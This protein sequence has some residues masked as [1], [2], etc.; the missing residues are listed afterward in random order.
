MIKCHKTGGFF[1]EKYCGV[2]D[3]PTMAQMTFTQCTSI[4]RDL[5][6]KP[7]WF[8][9][10]VAAALYTLPCGDASHKSD[11]PCSNSY[12]SAFSAKA[13]F[14]QHKLPTHKQGS[15]QETWA[16]HG[17][18]VL[19]YAACYLYRTQNSGSLSRCTFDTALQHRLYKTE[20]S[21]AILI[22]ILILC[23]IR[24]LL[25]EILHFQ[26]YAFHKF[27]MKLLLKYH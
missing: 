11:V 15:F 19:Q 22:M 10:Q 25:S 27:Q 7:I 20:H 8:S 12:F 21:L 3:L 9:C 24:I 5:F 14:G 16:L 2:P 6:W 13:T 23:F 4:G 18:T 26:R 17:I 1:P